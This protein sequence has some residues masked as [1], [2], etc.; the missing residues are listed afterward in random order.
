MVWRCKARFYSE[1]ALNP[2]EILQS[3]RSVDKIF[4][5]F[6]AEMNIQVHLF[7]PHVTT[8]AAAL[9]A[10]TDVG[11]ASDSAAVKDAILHEFKWSPSELLH[12]FTTL[13][14]KR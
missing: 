9:V 3:F 1:N 7:K 13:V 12:R 10:R 11:V 4:A 8:S 14:K 5:D 2:V 6:K